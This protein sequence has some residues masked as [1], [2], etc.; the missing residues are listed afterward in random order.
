MSQLLVQS[1]LS[2]CA[3]LLRNQSKILDQCSQVVSIFWRYFIDIDHLLLSHDYR[4]I[5]PSFCGTSGCHQPSRCTRP[6]KSCLSLFS[7]S[8]SWSDCPVRDLSGSD[9]EC[10][11]FRAPT[12]SWQT[13]SLIAQQIATSSQCQVYR[14]VEKQPRRLCLRCSL[15]SGQQS[16]GL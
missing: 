11:H 9:G 14:S 12:Q 6:W 16:K 2:R 3:E 1:V 4:N 10:S 15:N 5:C 7:S 8:S 13:R